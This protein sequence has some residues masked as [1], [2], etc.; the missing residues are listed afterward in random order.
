MNE[1]EDMRIESKARRAAKRVGLNMTKSRRAESA[2]N[3]G[4]FMLINSSA[5]SIV[6][7]E[8]YDMTAEQVIAYCAAQEK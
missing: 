1:V 4:H 7:G 5:N 6:A 8:K 3:L 2:D